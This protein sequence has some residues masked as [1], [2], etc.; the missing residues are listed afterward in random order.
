MSVKMGAEMKIGIRTAVPALPMRSHDPK[1]DVA[2]LC[3]LLPSLGDEGLL[4]IHLRFWEHMTIQE[5]AKFLGRSWTETD[6]LIESTIAEL[7]KGF[8]ERTGGELMLTA[9]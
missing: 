2:T 3:N 6:L 9:A 4:A 5:I 8:L 7:R 1:H